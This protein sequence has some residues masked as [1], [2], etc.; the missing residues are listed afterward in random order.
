MDNKNQW[1]PEKKEVA[2]WNVRC[3]DFSNIERVNE[4]IEKNIPL[5]ELLK[6]VVEE[7][8]ET[9]PV[10][11][12]VARL[13]YYKQ[14]EHPQN[15]KRNYDYWDSLLSR[16]ID[17]TEQEYRGKYKDLE[18]RKALVEAVIKEFYHNIKEFCEHPIRWRWK[19]LV[20]K[21]KRLWRN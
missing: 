6:D 1:Q 14:K 12:Y 21:I 2:V 9:D 10:Y 18:E 4:W 15:K 20:K 5:Q 17:Y 3:A 7:C 13:Y 19:R 16:H 11:C 8:T